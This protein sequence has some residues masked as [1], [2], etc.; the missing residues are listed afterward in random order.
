MMSRSWNETSEV[1]QTFKNI[2]S[3]PTTRPHT[4]HWGSQAQT[5]VQRNATHQRRAERSS[6]VPTPGQNFAPPP[7]IPKWD[8]QVGRRSEESLGRREGKDG[9]ASLEHTESKA[10]AAAALL[11]GSCIPSWA[12]RSGGARL[13]SS[14]RASNR[15]D[16]GSAPSLSEV[17]PL[18][19]LLDRSALPRHRQKGD[20]QRRQWLRHLPHCLTR[21]PTRPMPLLST[22]PESVP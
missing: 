10:A 20:R 6:H 9:F 14:R 17:P 5:F 15:P 11:S 3:L 7:S 1:K 12:E 18:G 8:G 22:R 13:C 21:S 2:S 4:P 16:P 19:D